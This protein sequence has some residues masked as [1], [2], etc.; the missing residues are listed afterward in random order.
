M[1]CEQSAGDRWLGMGDGRSAIPATVC[2]SVSVCNVSITCHTLGR[3][4]VLLA[5]GYLPHSEFNND[6]AER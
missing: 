2:R 3:V 5:Q 1:P 4:N 6:I